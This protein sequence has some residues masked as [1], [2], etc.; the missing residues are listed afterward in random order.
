MTLS[1]FPHS[2]RAA[3]IVMLLS[4]LAGC[5]DSGVQEVQ[6]WMDET[7]RQTRIV[8]P[9]LSE[10]KTFTPF[11]YGGKSAVDP[12]S[13]AKL[14]VALA[15]QKSSSESAFKPNLDRRREPLEAYPLD[16]LKMVGTLRKAG[17][18][19]A[20]LQAD[21]SLFQ[22]KVGNYIGQNF[23]MVTKIT[24]S[25]VEL[26]EIVQDASGEWVERNAKLELQESKK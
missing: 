17:A 4:A 21:K 11:I 24:E 3:L 16:N 20:L 26:K 15:K 7:K 18:S 23:G 13:P 14:A 9:K 6:Q 10:P 2:A 19:Y 12:Y 1:H 8:I 22:V 5:G 25:E